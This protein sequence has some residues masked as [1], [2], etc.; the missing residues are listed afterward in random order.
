MLSFIWEARGDDEG[1]VRCGQICLFAI[2]V[3]LQ[4]YGVIGCSFDVSLP[5][6]PD[7]PEFLYVYFNYI[8]DVLCM[9]WEFRLPVIIYGKIAVTPCNEYL[10]MSWGGSEFLKRTVGF[11]LMFR[12]VCSEHLLE[13]A[14][15]FFNKVTYCITLTNSLPG[16]CFT[17]SYNLHLDCFKGSGHYW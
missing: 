14:S 16:E 13:K 1:R 3:C 11:K 7:N 10:S 8:S 9:F 12:S 2:F 4:C 6:N 15:I 17:P 5:D